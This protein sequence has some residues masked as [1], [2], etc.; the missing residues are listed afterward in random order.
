MEK[1]NK[2]KQ[3]PNKQNKTLRGTICSSQSKHIEKQMSIFCALTSLPVI[4]VGKVAGRL[5][6]VVDLREIITAFHWISIA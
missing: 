1:K 6:I 5:T 3:N 2:T 4:R